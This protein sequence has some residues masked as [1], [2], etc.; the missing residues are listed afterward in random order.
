MRGVLLLACGIWPVCTRQGGRAKSMIVLVGLCLQHL[1][2]T[3]H[4]SLVSECRSIRREP[5]RAERTCIKTRCC[6]THQLRNLGQV[7]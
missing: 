1:S 6:L 4:P 5:G 2:L 3:L 7:S